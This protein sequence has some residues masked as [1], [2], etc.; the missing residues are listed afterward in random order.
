MKL[1]KIEHAILSAN[2]LDKADREEAEQE[3]ERQITHL[4]N[5]VYE[6][7]SEEQSY[8][9][10]IT[11][12]DKKLRRIFHTD[13]HDERGVEIAVKAVIQ[14][15]I[16]VENSFKW[17]IMREW[18]E[19]GLG[20][21]HYHGIITQKRGGQT[22]M[23]HLQGILKR[24]FGRDCRIK[25]IYELDGYIMYMLKRTYQ[26]GNHLPNEWLSSELMHTNFNDEI[27]APHFTWK[28]IEDWNLEHKKVE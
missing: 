15:N 26:E 25:N 16:R 11:F 21:L 2:L 8:E 12:D 22:E 27:N 13:I 7:Y 19:A 17:F 10:T 28:D 5:M 20:R 23:A 24:Y 18:S 9:M 4:H 14:S 1:T 3:D 6:D